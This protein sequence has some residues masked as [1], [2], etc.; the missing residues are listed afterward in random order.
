MGNFLPAPFCVSFDSILR[1][2][3]AW[4]VG[5][6]QIH[7]LQ[8]GTH[9]NLI[10]QIREL[11]DRKKIQTLLSLSGITEREVSY[12]LKEPPALA[13]VEQKLPPKLRSALNKDVNEKGEQRDFAF[14]QLSSP[15]SSS[16]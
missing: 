10:C 9:W 15:E 8:A 4:Y 14:V 13:I 1:F 6:H 16:W 7:Q 11:E 5:S 3:V 12:F 2:V